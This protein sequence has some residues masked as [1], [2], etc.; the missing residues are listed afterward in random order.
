MMILQYVMGDSPVNRPEEP[1]TT[2]RMRSASSHR[3]LRT[4]RETADSNGHMGRSYM[5]AYI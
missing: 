4:V 5:H 1:A 3:L 2:M